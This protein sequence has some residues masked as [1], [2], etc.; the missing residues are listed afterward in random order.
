ME[1]G[2]QMLKIIH[3]MKELD[4]GQ[5]MSVYVQSNREHGVQ[6]DPGL[7]ENEQLLQAEQELYCYIQEFLASDQAF[8]AVWVS[9]VRYVAALR[10]EPYL[11]GL[12][13]EALET[14]PEAR[15]NGCAT[16]LVKSTLAYLREQGSTVVYA[17][18]SKSNLASL[19]VH[20]AC[21]FEILKDHARYIDGS[22][23]NAAYTLRHTG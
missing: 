13:L 10:M 1:R 11:D 12:L 4:L 23:S 21:G 14:A 22:F 17:H 15:G 19:A 6:H 7:S 16:A 3:S 5:L 20:K 9:G 2:K 8:Y 18:I